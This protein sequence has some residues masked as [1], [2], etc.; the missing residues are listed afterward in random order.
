MNN[1]YYNLNFSLALRIWRGRI[2]NDSSRSNFVPAYMGKEDG[3][4][5]FFYTNKQCLT[6]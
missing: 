2:E 4:A 6:P 5:F 1:K 3:R